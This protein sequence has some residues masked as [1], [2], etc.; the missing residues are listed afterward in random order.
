MWENEKQKRIENT[1]IA[2]LLS[3]NGRKI[4]KNIEL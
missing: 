2:E 3:E 1:E 4:K